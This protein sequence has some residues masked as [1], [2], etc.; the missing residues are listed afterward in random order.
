VSARDRLTAILGEAIRAVDA[1]AAVE[2]ALPG[3][4]TLN[5]A[6]V[7]V[8]AIGKAACAMLAPVEASLGPRIRA[9]L[10]ITK[11]GHT[12]PRPASGQGSG[13]GSGMGSEMGL[14]VLETAHP[15]PDLRCE[16][17]A[18]AAL[19]LAANTRPDETLLVLL[20]GGTS[21]LTACPAP[22]LQLED[23]AAV[24]RAL[25]ASGADIHEINCVRKHL[26][27]FGGGRLAEASG[28]RSIEVLA[29]SDV[30]GDD[31]GTI[32]SGPCAP[33]ETGFGDALE[34]V[35]Q[36]G[37]RGQLPAA[38]AAHLEAGVRGERPETPVTGD[39]LF[40]QVRHTI[41]ASNADARE[42]AVAA[43]RRQGL[44]PVALGECLF[45]EA[46]ERG[47]WLVARARAA[48]SGSGSCLVAG[49]ETT[50]TLRG[51]G[52]GGR[53]QE[54]ALAAAIELFEGRDAGVALLAAGTDGSDGPT[55]AAGA[56]VDSA[57]V[58]RGAGQGVDA[59]VA[60]AANDAYGFFER[61]GGLVK[62][63]PTG[64]NV[65]DLALVEIAAPR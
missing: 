57:S 61:E 23:L 40:E 59:Q 38:V 63:G 48:G 50:V 55:D 4:R 35:V 53:S 5:G 32:G 54:L 29:V 21:A 49:G 37:L 19:E 12:G 41:V 45:G 16:R 36:R 7:V 15:V 33:D 3:L 25:L 14:P 24:T 34:V 46:S 10:A 18:R 44:E 52:R 11:D 65:M 64:T 42:A 28:T 43:A 6:G 22:G 1:G 2:R 47:R 62:T 8:L 58:S 60:L 26:S 51:G 31:I 17:A 56:F 39:P 13:Q 20:S 27:A 30:A 9:G